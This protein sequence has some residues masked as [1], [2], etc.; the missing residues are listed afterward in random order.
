MCYNSSVLEIVSEIQDP[1][2]SSQRMP[3]GDE[4][5]DNTEKNDSW[6][7]YSIADKVNDLKVLKEQFE[8]KNDIAS[9][10]RIARVCVCVSRAMQLII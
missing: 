4:E 6:L 10:E 5:E 1:L 3:F 7:S 8:H 2:E 9:A